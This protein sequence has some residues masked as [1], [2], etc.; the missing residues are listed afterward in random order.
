[1]IVGR[2]VVPLPHAGK[3]RV[4]SAGHER[5]FAVAIR[6]PPNAFEL[7][8]APA[9]CSTV[10]RT[11]SQGGRT[12]ASLLSLAQAGRFAGAPSWSGARCPRR[13]R[14]ASR[15]AARRRPRRRQ[16]LVEEAGFL[17]R[18]APRSGCQHAIDQN[19]PLQRNGQRIA[20]TNGG[21]LTGLLA[22]DPHPARLGQLGRKRTRFDHA[23]EKQP[24]VDALSSLGHLLLQL[25]PERRKLGEGR[26]RIEPHRLFLARLRL[27]GRLAGAL[28]LSV[29]LGLAFETIAVAVRV[30]PAWR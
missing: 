30:A 20:R 18:P 2:D 22:V 4:I 3:C 21:G 27:E 13:A 25:V 16:I 14:P 1:M 9:Y 26:I 8:A 17:C 10:E 19:S 15:R 5:Q 6:E 24:L 29:S 7:Q 12:R 11:R 28:R 23:R